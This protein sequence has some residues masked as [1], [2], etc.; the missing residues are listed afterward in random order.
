MARFRDFF[1]RAKKQPAESAN[2]YTCTTKLN[3][4]HIEY[5][6]SSASSSDIASLPVAGMQRSNQGTYILT[7][8]A[9][10]NQD[11]SRRQSCDISVD[12]D[13]SKTAVEKIAVPVNTTSVW[14][15]A[16]KGTQYDKREELTEE[17]EEMWAKM[18]M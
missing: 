18:A 7:H 1:R 4:Q 14:K 16:A 10:R 11:L 12:S 8:T 6:S 13:S 9:A 3:K 5:D 17:D 2:H 15:S